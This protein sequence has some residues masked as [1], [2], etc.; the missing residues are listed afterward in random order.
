M[1]PV[2]V[3][4]ERAGHSR[5][6]GTGWLVSCPLR[7]HGQGRGD[8]NPSV[9][10]TKGDDGRALVNCQAGCET[11]DIVA[12]WGL[13]MADLF[14]CRNGHRGGGSYTSPKT[15]ST[16]QPAT[17]EN[18]AAY[19]GLPVEFLKLLGLKEYRHLGEPA[20]SMPYLDENGEVLLTRSRVSLTGKP[21][22]KTRKG[23]KHRLYGLWKLEDAR[24]VGY[25]WMCEGESDMQTLWYHEEPALG[26]PGANGWKAEW[27][28]DLEGVD[29]LYFVIEDEAGE[30]CWRKLAETPEIRDRLYRVELEGVKD[31]S[32][33]HKRDR[34][35]FQ[36]EAEKGKGRRPGVPRY[37]RN[38]RAGARQRGVG[39]VPGAGREPGHTRRFLRGPGAVP[40]RGRANERETPLP[41]PDKP[42]SRQDRERRGQGAIFGGQVV[43][44][45]ERRGLLPRRQPS[46]S[47]PRS[48]RRPST[49]PRSLFR[50]AT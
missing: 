23:D 41:R 27:A 3:V 5:E 16:D 36:G 42:P 47:S 45:R 46:T 17:L 22:V 14:E 2:E 38:R 20:V 8:R 4:L 24:R 50:T 37:R 43:P 18:Y 21:K 32:E 7:D 34:R 6:A 1:G 26:I 30:Q 39:I 40:R 35:R 19:V 12:E 13:T 49:T 29:R 44:R 28:A 31:V 10:V 11:E 33:L 15:T 48:R 9:S 25:A